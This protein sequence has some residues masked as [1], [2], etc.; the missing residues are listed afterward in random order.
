MFSQKNV[1]QG[2]LCLTIMDFCYALFSGIYES[3]SAKLK[4][5]IL[6]FTTK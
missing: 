5:E 6:R 4:L 3:E 2:H 1:G